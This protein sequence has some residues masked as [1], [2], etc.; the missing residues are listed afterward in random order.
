MK[1]F[2]IMDLRQ[3]DILNQ[4]FFQKELARQNRGLQSGHEV[5]TLPILI[6][7]GSL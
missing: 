7:A 4:R 6:L 1:I 3:I 5:G 2:E